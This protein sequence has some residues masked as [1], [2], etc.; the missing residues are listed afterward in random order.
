MSTTWK[1]SDQSAKYPGLSGDLSVDV[2]VVGGGITG[3]VNAYTLAKAGKQ[4]AL[5]EKDILGAGVTSMTTAFITAV[6]DTDYAKLVRAVGVA[7]AKNIWQSHAQA[8][9][10]LEQ[11]IV[12]EQIACDFGR[13]SD[14]IYASSA[15]D[16]SGIEKEYEIYRRFGAPASL[17]RDGAALRFENHGY[18]ELPNQAKFDPEKFMTGLVAAARRAGVQLFEET[19][20]SEVTTTGDGAT[21]RTP[22][23]VIRARDV[24]V[25]T[26]EPLTNQKTLFKK[27]MYRSYVLEASIPS[28]A[29][30][31][32]MYEDSANPYHYFRVDHREEGD[33]IIFGGEDH[34]DSFGDILK[35]K[36]FDGLKKSAARLLKGVPHTITKMWW[37]PILE[38]SDGLALIGALEPHYYIATAFSGNGMT[39]AMI[40]ARVIADLM[41]GRGGD[42]GKLY[43]PLRTIRPGLLLTKVSD[44]VAE[45]FGGAL[46]NIFR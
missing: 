40:S 11:I 28:G 35:K 39:Y 46:K 44:Y 36:S 27:G 38:P 29:F 7:E 31:E 41:L 1:T 30:L 5:I 10:D 23:G 13:C 24:V 37:G 42:V 2:V 20:A 14:Y 12:Q 16:F 22:G 3:L 26:Y 6:I 19:E 18:L 17:H 4:V 43:D 15:H 33:R 21:V 45:F 34:R 32:G 25:A 8:I 9:D